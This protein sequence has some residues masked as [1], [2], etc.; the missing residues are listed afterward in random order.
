MEKI[1]KALIKIAAV[2]LTIPATLQ[3]SGSLYPHDPALR[4]MVQ[5]AGVVLI[6]GAMLL[7]W[8][9]LDASDGKARPAQLWLYAALVAVAYLGLNGIAILHGEGLTG[10]IFRATLGV[11]IVYSIVDSGILTS[12]RLTQAADRSIRSTARV[13]R[14]ARACAQAVAIAEQDLERDLALDAL[15]RRRALETSRRSVQSEADLKA[16]RAASTPVVQASKSPNKAA[17]GKRPVRPAPDVSRASRLPVLQSIV[18]SSPDTSKPDLI[19]AYR[20][21]TGVG[22]STAYADLEA[23]SIP[24]PNGH[25]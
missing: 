5:A 22:R 4:L 8:H 25:H 21:A 23:L 11:L 7:G 12:V 16:V 2:A 19:R 13:R 15:N 10:L 18:A 14:H 24:A 1:L 9:G 17:S 6:E 3:M 20:D